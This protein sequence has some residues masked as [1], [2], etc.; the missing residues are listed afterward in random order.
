MLTINIF[1]V[2]PQPKKVATVP[3]CVMQVN[4]K[5]IEVPVTAIFKGS[6]KIKKGFLREQGLL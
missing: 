6:K 1:G 4:G 3:V 2:N 5:R